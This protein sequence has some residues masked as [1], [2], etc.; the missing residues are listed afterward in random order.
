M[1]IRAHATYK[2][3]EFAI[4]L[5]PKCA[6]GCSAVTI[7]LSHR[8]VDLRRTQSCRGKS[9]VLSLRLERLFYGVNTELLHRLAK[10][11]S[12]SDCEV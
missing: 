2:V 1:G 12:G 10:A 9:Q 11:E 4:L 7:E 6:E 8:Q 3:D 5:S